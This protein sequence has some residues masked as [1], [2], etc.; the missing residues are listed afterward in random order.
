MAPGKPDKPSVQRVKP[1]VK[2]GIDQISW[3]KSIAGEDK[4][5]EHFVPQHSGCIFSQMHV[6]LSEIRNKE[7]KIM[8]KPMP[9]MPEAVF[10]NAILDC[11]FKRSL[12]LA[13]G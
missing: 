11:K 12:A 1:D 13:R 10:G 2:I 6:L 8:S 5:T 9:P 7:M 4:A 3:N